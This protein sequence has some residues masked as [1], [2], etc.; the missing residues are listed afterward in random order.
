MSTVHLDTSGTIN[1]CKWIADIESKQTSANQKTAE[2]STGNLCTNLS[3]SSFCFL[4]RLIANCHLL[5][6]IRQQKSNTKGAGRSIVIKQ[7]LAI[8][9]KVLHVPLYSVSTPKW[10]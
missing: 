7:A 8:A 3:I 5:E 10:E 1:E 4:L 6:P 9:V 2:A